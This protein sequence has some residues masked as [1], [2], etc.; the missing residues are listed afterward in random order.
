MLEEMNQELS[1]LNKKN[2]TQN[3]L[4]GFN[5]NQIN[6]SDPVLTFNNFRNDFVQKNDSII[7]LT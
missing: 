1:R 7:A 3:I 2:S 5:L 6:Q 4:K